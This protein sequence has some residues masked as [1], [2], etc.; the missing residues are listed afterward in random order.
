M[1][2]NCLQKGANEEEE[3]NANDAEHV[4]EKDA[5]VRGVDVQRQKLVHKKKAP[6]QKKYKMPKVKTAKPGTWV[7]PHGHP[8]VP[9]RR[10]SPRTHY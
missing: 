7:L 9:L 1:V 6:Q 4:E 10:T 5:R 2:K 3:E 8:S